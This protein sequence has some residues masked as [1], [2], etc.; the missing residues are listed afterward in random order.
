MLFAALVENVKVI[1]TVVT[2]AVAI[3]TGYFF[4]DPYVPATKSYVIAQAE[5]I[6]ADNKKETE[7]IRK[8]TKGIKN[9]LVDI[10][11]QL[12]SQQRSVLRSEKTSRQIELEAKPDQRHII[13]QKID[14]IDDDL[15]EIQKQRERLLKQREDQ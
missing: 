1:S 11:L 5:A 12:N 15:N 9:G 2:S 7:I 13:Q 6:K 10:Q 4:F 8:E 3:V 14:Q